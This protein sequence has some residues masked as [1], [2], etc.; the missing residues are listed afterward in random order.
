MK[1][2]WLLLALAAAL[3]GCG[4]SAEMKK[5]E[6]DLNAEIQKVHDKQMASMK[7]LDSLTASLDNAL[8]RHTELAAKYSKA[9]EGHSADDITAAKEQIAGAKSA[10]DGWMKAY[11]PYDE[12]LPHEQ[13][14]AQLNKD[15][16]GLMGMQTQLDAAMKGASE[17]ITSHAKAAEE[18]MAKFDK[19]RKK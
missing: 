16:E 2:R 7:V 3:I 5:L 11:K 4:K 18:V 19:R 10:M 14:M 15:M 1:S 12:T 17:V 6:A 8:A 9:L 13:V